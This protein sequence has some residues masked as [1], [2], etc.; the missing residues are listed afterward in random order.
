M[1]A[2][3]RLQELQ[4]GD[5]DN[6]SLSSGGS[7]AVKLP[8]LELPKFYGDV[9]E[10]Q[11]FWDQFSSHIDNTDLPDISKFSYLLSLL[12]GEAT[13]CVQ[14]LSLTT[15]NYKIACDL[16]KERFGRSEQI[17]FHHVQ[18]LLSGN[19][20]VKSKGSKY[21]SSLWGMHDEFLTHIRSLEALG[22][23]GKQCATFLT[24]I[25]LSC[26]PSEIRLE[27]A[28]KRAGLESD[29]E[30]LL[31][32]LQEKIKNIERSKTFKDLSSWKPESLGLAEYHKSKNLGP[33]AYRGGESSASALHVATSEVDKQSCVFCS[34]RHKAEN[35]YELL[36]LSGQDRANKIKLARVCFKCLGKGHLAKGC[37]AKC[38]KC[39]G[40]HNVLMCGIRLG[41]KSVTEGS[42]KVAGSGTVDTD[43]V[44][45]NESENPTSNHLTNHAGVTLYN[46]T[47]T[48]NP[49]T[50][51]PTARV[52]D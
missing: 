37:L 24:P 11:S 17:I 44:M 36:K 34:K 49:C 12:E 16:L 30:W 20:P 26:L 29:L 2:K 1:L 52:Y 28:R 5:D 51:L 50:I 27:W 8:K 9:T 19:V 23:S 6:A 7:L 38:S 3:K 14:G 25:I 31:T 22:V 4:K 35:C 39:S 41:N 10:W 21:V 13:V 47:S 43:T 42:V 46:A 48:T 45:V 18:A 33:R 15:V 32:F 40:R